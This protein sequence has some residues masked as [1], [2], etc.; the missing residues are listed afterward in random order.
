[1]DN[2]DI[3]QYIRQHGQS[4]TDEL[5]LRWARQAAEGSA[6]LQSI[7]VIHCDISPRNFLLD[8]DLNLRISD[9]GGASLSGS[10][11]TAVAQTRF[12]HPQ[13]DWDAP[14]TVGDDIFSLGL[15]IHFVMI[16]SYPYADRDSDEVEKLYTSQ[17]FPDVTHLTRGSIICQCWTRNVLASE[18]YSHIKMLEENRQL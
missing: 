2:G 5:R 7:G 11:P 16:G 6:A 9:F 15:L 10:A 4:L 12:R 17:H 18:V 13:F 8:R 3:G 1:M 14:P